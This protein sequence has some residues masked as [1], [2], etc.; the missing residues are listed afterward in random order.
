[1]EILQQLTERPTDG[2]NLILP[3]L[4][5]HGSARRRST[6]IKRPT[7]YGREIGSLMWRRSLLLITFYYEITTFNIP[8]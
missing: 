3:S 2:P 7:R 6:N 5:C 8:A 1:M 4:F